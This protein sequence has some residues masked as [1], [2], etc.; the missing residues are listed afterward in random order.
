MLRDHLMEL[1]NGIEHCILLIGFRK[2]N[3]PSVALP[4]VSFPSLSI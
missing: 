4:A 3:P 1:D 2:M